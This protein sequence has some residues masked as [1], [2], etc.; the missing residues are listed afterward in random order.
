MNVWY[1][2]ILHT[3]HKIQLSPSESYQIS[4]TI[5]LNYQEESQDLSALQCDP[6]KL[7]EYLECAMSERPD[8]K[9]KMKTSLKYIE[10]LSAHQPMKVYDELK[11]H[12]YPLHEVEKIL[13][14]GQQHRE[15]LA[16][17]KE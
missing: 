10:L 9:V 11:R 16:Y 2:Y 6:I 13:S 8:W 17:I 7:L 1:V 15:G 3:P 14:V 12:L 4:K 5:G